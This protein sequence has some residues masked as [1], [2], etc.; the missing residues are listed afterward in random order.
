MTSVKNI[1]QSDCFV[2]IHR[3]GDEQIFYENDPN[4]PI[5]ACYDDPLQPSEVLDIV[6]NSLE[7]DHRVKPVS[8]H[9]SQSSPT[10]PG[11]E[12]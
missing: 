3:D 12:V 9:E 5:Y 2:Y 10:P 1:T 7:N 8:V 11:Y 6:L 4:L